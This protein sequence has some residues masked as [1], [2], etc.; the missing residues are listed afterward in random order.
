[1]RGIFSIATVA[2]MIALAGPAR[3][4]DPVVHPAD[5]YGYGYDSSDWN[6]LRGRASWREPVVVGAAPYV[7]ADGSVVCGAPVVLR[8]IVRERYRY[9]AVPRRYTHDLN[10]GG[11]PAGAPS[12]QYEF[13]NP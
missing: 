3:A 4:H 8:R 2:L 6:P 11:Y 12:Y 13:Y 1:M 5:P 7:A 9:A 10:L